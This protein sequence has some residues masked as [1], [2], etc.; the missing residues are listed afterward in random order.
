MAITSENISLNVVINGDNAMKELSEIDAQ[1][2][3]IGNTVKQLEAQKLKMIKANKE[4]TEEYKRLNKE[5]DLNIAVMDQNKKKQDELRKGIDINTLSLRQLRKELADVKRAYDNATPGTTAHTEAAKRVQALSGRINELSLSSKKARGDWEEF[6]TSIGSAAIKITGIIALISGFITAV[7]KIVNVRAEFEKYEAIL[8]NLYLGNKERMKNTLADIKAFAAKTPFEVGELV[9]LFIKLR[10]SISNL[11]FTESSFTKLGDF[12]AATGPSVDQLAEAIKDINNSERWKEFQVKVENVGDKVRMTF[13]GQTIEVEKTQAAVMKAVEVFGAMKGVAGGMDAVAKTTTGSLSNM[14]DS[15]NNLYNTIGEKIQPVT[16]LV[17]KSITS[18]FDGL[19]NFF[20]ADWGDKVK[21][22]WNGIIENI[23][24]IGS[25]G[26]NKIAKMWG[27]DIKSTLLQ[28]LT[29]DIKPKIDATN[30]PFIAQIEAQQ[31]AAQKM[32]EDRE[33]MEAKLKELTKPLSDEQKKRLKELEDANR[34]LNDM[35]LGFNKDQIT[36]ERLKAFAELQIWKEK[37]EEKIL[38][39]KA[40]KEI[41]DK[42]LLALDAAYN[43]KSDALDIEFKNK[44]KEKEKKDLEE[45]EKKIK[46]MFDLYKR[47]IEGVSKEQEK[48]RKETEK[49]LGGD[50]F[51]GKLE[52]IDK[53]EKAK[54]AKVKTAFEQGLIT[55]KEFETAKTNITK[56]AGEERQK[57]WEEEVVKWAEKIMSVVDDTSKITI[58][59][60]DL[61]TQKVETAN[62]KQLKAY[63]EAKAQELKIAGEDKDKKQAV[64]D[65]YAKLEADLA[66]STEAKKKEITKRYADIEMAINIARIIVNTAVGVAKA[67]PNV[68]LMVVAGALG[69]IEVGIAIA[70]RN[71]V[72]ALA[73]G[74]YPVLTDSGKTYNAELGTQNKTTIYRRPVLVAEEGAEAVIDHN[75][76]YSGK[77]DEYDMRPMDYYNRIYRMKFNSPVRSFAEGNYPN[78]NSNSTSPAQSNDAILSKLDQ[79][80]MVQQAQNQKIDNWANSLNVS[81]ISFE[82]TQKRVNDL[83]GDVNFNPST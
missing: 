51:S 61:E 50:D 60:K 14:T 24:T 72:K 78:T 48:L 59:L 69:A 31:K 75:T 56:E 35:I 64:N 44:E 7:M 4:E 13:R 77:R 74:Q 1:N 71:Q 28:K 39:S 32:I 23:S 52:D 83:R 3:K 29:F 8:T 68:A 53:E 12:A 18:I 25:F 47:Y 49:Y 57:L 5:L 26:L 41:K 36:D 79:F 37:E 20:Q 46:K 73:Q 76:L 54:L 43:S 33:D 9:N 67:I 11:K 62:A 82:Q 34:E 80:I 22:F 65:K 45:K 70:Q 81:W 63:K 66:E 6:K 19:T 15:L 16:S 27:L 10:G 21:L 40:S 38:L 2:R 55:Q 58:G 42:A 17:I 30:N